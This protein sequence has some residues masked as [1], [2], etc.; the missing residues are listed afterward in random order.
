MVEHGEKHGSQGTASGKPDASEAVLLAQEDAVE[1]ANLARRRSG[2]SLRHHRPLI[3]VMRLDSEFGT[4]SAFESRFRQ[5]RRRRWGEE[6]WPQYARA[7]E[8]QVAAMDIEVRTAALDP[9]T[10]G[11]DSAG[12][13]DLRYWE[14]NPRVDA[15]D[16]LEKGWRPRSRLIRLWRLLSG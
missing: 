15:A 7:Y 4:G 6:V 14:P 1:D 5:W 10:D 9:F 16:P 13:I 2:G 11:W 8:A 3:P 12:L